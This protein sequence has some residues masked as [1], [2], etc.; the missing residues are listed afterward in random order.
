MRLTDKTQWAERHAGGKSALP[1][2]DVHAPMFRERHAWF[3]R[4]LPRN[5]NWTVLEIGAFPGTNLRYFH[6]HFGFQPWGVE[7]VEG[8]A[9]E[10]QRLLDDAGVPG[11]ILARDVFELMP[12]EA[13]GA[14]G[15]DVTVSF[16][17]IEHFADPTDAI[18][19]HVELTKP[20]GWILL[21]VPN[22]A[23]L[24]GTVMRWLD[25]DKWAQHNLMPLRT[26]EASIR[27]LPDAGL[28]DARHLGRFGFWNAGIYSKA[29]RDYPSLYPAIRAPLWTAEHLG[30]W[31]V[32]NNPWSSPE[33]V[34][35][36]RKLG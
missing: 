14:A 11:R 18:V 25:R 10:A 8:S 29:K 7:Y 6:D 34:A 12:D 24:N 26:M 16:G 36:L 22:H 28:V 13:P 1:R 2:L 27:R 5:P 30:Q 23:G 9:Q 32:P 21:S 19:K 35:A 17:F 15:W 31:L 33:L 20:G 3:G 4:L